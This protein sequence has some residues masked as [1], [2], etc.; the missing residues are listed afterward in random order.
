MTSLRTPQPYPRFDGG[1][2]ANQTAWLPGLIATLQPH[3]VALNG[4]TLSPN[5]TRWIGSESG[6]APNETWS[7]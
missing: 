1:F 4:Q 2:T 3:A 7:T 6:Y 5:P